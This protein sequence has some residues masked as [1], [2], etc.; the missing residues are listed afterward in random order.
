MGYIHHLRSVI[1]SLSIMSL[2]TLVKISTVNNLSDARYGAGMGVAMMG[3]PVG[4]EHP[5]YLS[6]EQFQ[7]ITQWVEGV[8][9]VGELFTTDPVVIHDTLEAYPLDYLQ[10]V[11]GVPIPRGG[12]WGIPVLIQLYLNGDET[13]ESLQSR[14]KVYAPYVKYFLLESV[15][16]EE[17]AWAKLQPIV[18]RL[19][20][21][22]PILQGYQVTPDTLPQLLASPLQGIALHGGT[23]IK[24]GYK[25]FDQL[26][27]VL[28]TLATD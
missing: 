18:D 7:A 26:A 5:H 21:D 12:D 13:L 4:Q 2:K 14:M 22:F 20:K 15:A 16:M 10:L 25:A 8:A 19:A 17:A 24:P 6:P 11:D 23:E 28:E 1:H 27:V 3:F 9:L